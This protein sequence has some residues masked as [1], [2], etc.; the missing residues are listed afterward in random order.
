[1]K[2]EKN[3]A[4]TLIELL[5]VVLIVGILA[6]VALPRYQMAVAKARVTEVLPLLNAIRTAQEVHYMANGAYSDK[7]DDLGVGISGV[8]SVEDCNSGGLATQC[9]YFNTSYYCNV[10]SGGGAAYCRDRTGALPQIGVTFANGSFRKTFGLRVCISLDDWEER[11][12]KALGGT[13]GPSFG[14]G[15]YYSF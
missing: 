13:L 1:M 6:A 10:N 2:S 15:K 9:F 12:C 4:F 14:P 7:W 3:A 5:V 8:T 11:V